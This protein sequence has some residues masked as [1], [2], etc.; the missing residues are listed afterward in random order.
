MYDIG[1]LPTEFCSFLEF[2]AVTHHP[3][4]AFDV[5]DRVLPREQCAID[6]VGLIQFGPF[7]DCRRQRL[8]Q[9]FDPF[10]VGPLPFI[11]FLRKGMD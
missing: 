7:L 5:E 10:M 9:S 4:A 2:A 6:R 3:V 11:S 8:L 1:A